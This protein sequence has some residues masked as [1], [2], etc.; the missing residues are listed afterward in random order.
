MPSTISSDGGVQFAAQDSRSTLP[1]FIASFGEL[2]HMGPGELE[3]KIEVDI[4]GE[5]SGNTDSSSIRRDIGD[6]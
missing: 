5:R 6:A 3:E 1:H 4:A 2:L